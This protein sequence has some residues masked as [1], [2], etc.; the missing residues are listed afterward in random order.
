MTIFIAADHAGFGLK[1]FVK[2]GLSGSE[3]R[4]VDFGPSSADSVDYPEF[5]QKV[6]V[7]LKQEP[8]AMGILICGSGQGMAMTANK[9]DHI[10]A[11]LCYNDE[12]TKL[13]RQ[14][15]NANIICL[16]SRGLSQD[17]ALK[18]IQTFVQ[19]PFEGG[20]HERRVSKIHS[21]PC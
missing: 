20:R 15:N 19:T 13:S 9:F 1:E 6:C 12:I 7:A 4:V 3:V 17:E 5:A 18:M 14:H 16:G 8:T 10:R 11:A 2:T 21:I